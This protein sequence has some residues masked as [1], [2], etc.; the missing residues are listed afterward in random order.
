MQDV[1]STL[2]RLKD[3]DASVLITGESGTGKELVAQAVHRQGSHGAGPLVAFNCVAVPDSMLESELFG[4]TRGAFTDANTNR[5]GLFTQANGGTLFL[6]EIGEMP[7]GTQVKLLRALQERTVRPIGSDREVPFNARLVYATSRDLETDVAEHRFREDLYYRINVIRIHMP[8][9]RSRGNDVLL[10]AEHFIRRFAEHS[11]K[12]VSGLEAEAAA[13]LLKYGWPGN[14]RELQNC[15]ERA[16]AL[17]DRTRITLE[18]LPPHISAFEGKHFVLPLENPLEL[19]SMDEVER[20]Y[21]LQVLQAV[22]GS[23][24]QAA[25]ALG[26]DR[27][28][29]HRKLKGYGVA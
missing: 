13:K 1:H 18:D 12:K 2:A 28:T 3:S 21:V 5:K 22:D 11:K 17:T 29:L 8:P 25:L 9:L 4:H 26:F 20:R 23:K 15:V 19:L 14:V 27:R 7:L 10:L 16:V 6:D 24:T